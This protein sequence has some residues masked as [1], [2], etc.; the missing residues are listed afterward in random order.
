MKKTLFILYVLCFGS[1]HYCVAQQAPSAKI[2]TAPEETYAGTREHRVQIDVYGMDGSQA[3]IKTHITNITALPGIT[4]FNIVI[5]EGGTEGY[6]DLRF[7]AS[8]KKEYQHMLR[9][10]LCRMD[11]QKVRVNEKTFTDCQVVIP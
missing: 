7:T 9:K 3:A 2:T 1:A 4:Y 11:I 6:C 10:V 5:P 8:D